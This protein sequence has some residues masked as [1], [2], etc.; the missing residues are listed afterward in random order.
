MTH[1]LTALG[2]RWES[3]V[4]T[5]LEGSR[6]VTIVR[7]CA[8]LPDLVATAA[9][10]LGTVALVSSDLRGLDLTV[11][12]QLRSAGVHVVGIAPDGDE[13]SERR[14]RQL[15]VGRIVPGS[16][17]L[18]ELEAALTEAAPPLDDSLVTLERDLDDELTDDLAGN[19]RRDGMPGPAPSA[20]VPA[21]L[22]RGGPQGPGEA[23]DE[24]RVDAAEGRVLA[25][26][27]PTGAPGR[28]TIAVTLASE[29]AGLGIPTVLVDADTY[30]GSV[31][32]A[33]SFLD[34]APGIAAASRAADQ[35]SL[36]LPTLARLAPV[37]SPGLR[38]L[39]G[40]PKAERWPEIRAAALE[41]VLTLC[42]SL[43]EVVIVDCGFSLEDDEE[44]SYDT[45]APRRN[46]ATLSTLGLA[47]EVVAV[48]ACDPVG[49][50]RLVRGLQELGTVPTPRPT[51][52]VNRVRPGAVGANPEQRVS[53]A[54]SRFAG[55][56]E[57]LFVPDDPSA[58]DTALLQ[59]RALAECAPQ[60]PVRPAVRSLAEKVAGAP[61]GS[62]RRRRRGLRV[63]R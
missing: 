30:G 61:A 2:N 59:G 10:G 1:V 42:R 54:L 17:E 40:I 51:V 29:L 47:D 20:A 35:G 26:W 11:V 31:A 49:L 33:L 55:V 13:D 32:Q 4:A 46:A 52:V 15:G 23:G 57:V 44:L 60:S 21:Y 18:A 5:L 34:E 43:G 22:D 25:I 16:V 50:Q 45:M 3:R 28:T 24:V 27:G 14:L 41:R 6:E 19:Q 39:T 53:E 48:G 9:A 12:A 58:L 8:D 63:S 37:A 62:G 36:D 7:R 38:V 56:T